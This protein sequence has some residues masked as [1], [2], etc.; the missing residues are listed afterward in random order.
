VFRNHAGKQKEK[1]L[2]Q[3]YQSKTLWFNIITLVVGVVAA[4][5]GLVETKV[6]VIILTAVNALGNGVLRIFFTN[7]AVAK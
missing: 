3:W 1:T 7:S 2:K 5:L 4:I 6:W